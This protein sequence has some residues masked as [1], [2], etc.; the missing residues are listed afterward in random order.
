MLPMQSRSELGSRQVYV[1]YYA[2]CSRSSGVYVHEVSIP[3]HHMIFIRRVLPVER[4]LLCRRSCGPQESIK[5]Y[6]GRRYIV[7]EIIKLADCFDIG[8]IP[9]ARND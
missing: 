5:E 1:H 4:S 7:W 6:A 2:Q 8:S 9:V 3:W